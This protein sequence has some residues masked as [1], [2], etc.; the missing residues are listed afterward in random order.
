MSEPEK[1]D[2]VEFTGEEIKVRK[3][4]IKENGRKIVGGW[5][6]N[7]GGC[8]SRHP[9]AWEAVKNAIDLYDDISS[10]RL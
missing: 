6:A 4:W 7:F 5:E 1:E 10:R 9:F 8:V 3:F 2:N